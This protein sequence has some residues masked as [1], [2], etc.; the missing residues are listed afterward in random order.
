M[1]K[2]FETPVLELISFENETSCIPNRVPVARF[3]K[4]FPALVN[5]Y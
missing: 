4:V 5:K 2:I 1:K 3:A